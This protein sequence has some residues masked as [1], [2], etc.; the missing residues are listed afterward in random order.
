MFVKA[1]HHFVLHDVIFGCFA[2]VIAYVPINIVSVIENCQTT[3]LS[4]STR[5]NL[6]PR[7]NCTGWLFVINNTWKQ[8]K[9]ELGHMKFH[10]THVCF[11][12]FSKNQNSYNHVCQ[13]WDTQKPSDTDEKMM[14]TMSRWCSQSMSPYALCPYGFFRRGPLVTIVAK[15]PRW[16]QIMKLKTVTRGPRQFSSRTVRDKK[17]SRGSA[18]KAYSESKSAARGPRYCNL[19]HFHLCL[20]RGVRDKNIAFNSKTIA[21]GPRRKQTMIWNKF[22]RPLATKTVARVSA[23]KEVSLGACDE[24]IQ[25]FCLRPFSCL[26]PIIFSCENANKHEWLIS[27]FSS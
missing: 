25:T 5:G 19:Q 12:I 17:L 20:S 7:T 16:K 22:R 9:A 1:I 18:T 11:E 13:I 26:S 23:T 10:C 24:T 15:G 4:D 2:C 3:F 21:R 27:F 8:C 14:M 6:R